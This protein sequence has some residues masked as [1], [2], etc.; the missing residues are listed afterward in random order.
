MFA[1][2]LITRGLVVLVIFISLSQGYITDTTSV[3]PSPCGGEGGVG[4]YRDRDV[5]TAGC[6]CTRG[7]SADRHYCSSTTYAGDH[8]SSGA[9][10]RD[11]RART[12]PAGGG[13]RAC[14]VSAAGHRA[15][16][17]SAT[18]R[19][20]LGRLFSTGL[21]AH[22]RTRPL[23]PPPAPHRVRASRTQMAPPGPAQ[24]PR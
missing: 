23:L 22:R 3:Q 2:R 20:R 10:A 17:I 16:S 18:G 12:T 14:T 11:R 4:R 9:Y 5:S 6:N 7:V 1:P 15:R 8:C 19:C 24:R 13:N 21:A